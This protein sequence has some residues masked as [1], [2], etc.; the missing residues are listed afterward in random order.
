MRLSGPTPGAVVLVAP[1]SARR[2]PGSLGAASHTW[3][4]GRIPVD[5]CSQ[6]LM[7]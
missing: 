2:V 3:E 1:V 5:F 4:T 6:T 7:L